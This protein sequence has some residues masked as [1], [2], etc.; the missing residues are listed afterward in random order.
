MKNQAPIKTVR[1]YNITE[2]HKQFGDF[3]LD[4]VRLHGVSSL[5]DAADIRQD[6]Y[7]ALFTQSITEK[8][9]GNALKGYL[10]RAVRNT[11]TDYR[12]TKKRSKIV[13]DWIEDN[14]K[15]NLGIKMDKSTFDE[16]WGVNASVHM[17]IIRAIEFLQDYEPIE[18]VRI[19]DIVTA[20][21]NGESYTTL[22]EIYQVPEGTIRSWVSRFRSKLRDHMR[23]GTN[24]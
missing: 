8:L 11:V 5:D 1:G 18:S 9:S 24:Q 7:M 21:Y 19:H 4:C 2:I 6:I 3:I 12:R 20:I 22:S 10:R 15:D 16:W 23:S 13:V 17:R 14:N